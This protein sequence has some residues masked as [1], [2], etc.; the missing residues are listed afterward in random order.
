MSKSSKIITRSDL[1]RSK[2]ACDRVER[3]IWKQISDMGID[4]QSAPRDVKQAIAQTRAPDWCEQ[5]AWQRMCES[6]VG[7]SQAHGSLEIFDKL[8]HLDD[9]QVEQWLNQ[10]RRTQ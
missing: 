2:V 8:P 7:W 4:V 9:K 6:F 5:E 10:R 1:T 3:A